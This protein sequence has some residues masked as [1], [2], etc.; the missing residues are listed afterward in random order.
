MYG[1]YVA[2]AHYILQQR[3]AV[4]FAGQEEWLRADR[5]GSFSWDFLHHKEVPLEAV[6]A[7]GSSMTYDGLENLVCLKELKH[8]N[9]S[10]C[11][12]IDDWCLSRLYVF[13]DSLEELVLSG[14]PRVT[15]RGL[16]SLHHLRKLKRLELSDLP[17]V[18][19]RGL[20][21]ILLEEWFAAVP[22]CGD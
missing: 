15:E 7:S 11:P 21:R 8:L 13:A 16:A 18:G 14:C 20:V 3:G 17:A 9:L 6:D 2:A 10:G 5:R 1:I 22:D 4:R 12:F 19:S